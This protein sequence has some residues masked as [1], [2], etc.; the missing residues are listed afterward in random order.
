MYPF[1]GGINQRNMRKQLIITL[2]ITVAGSASAQS[3]W[4]KAHL[5]EVK[6]NLQQ[7]AYQTAYRHLIGEA[8]KTLQMAC[9]SVMLKDRVPASGDKHDYLSLSRYF[10]PDPT[11]PDGLPYISRDGVSNPELERLDRNRLSEMASGVTTLALAWYFSGNSQYAEKATD[12]LRTW[13]INKDTR[14][15]PHLTYAQI[16]PG[17]NGDKGRCYGVIDSYSFVEMLDAVQL[18]EGSKAFTPRDSKALKGWFSKFLNWLL[19]SEQGREEARQSNNHATAYDVQVMAYARYVGN[20]QVMDEVLGQFYEKRMRPQIE[21]DGSQPQ[22]LRRTLAFGYSEY[23]LTHIIDVFQMAR[24]AG[25]QQ[26][27]LPLLE[28]AADFLAKYL[29]KPVEAWPWQQISGW[30]EKQNALCQDLYR[31]YLLDNSRT[32]YQQQ[33]RQHVVKRWSDRFFLLYYT[34]DETDHAFAQAD[35]QLRYQLAQADSIR[36]EQKDWTLM[37]RCV[38]R[39]GSLR[40]VRQPDWCCGFFSG[41]LWQM[42]QYSH[43]PF[44]R[45]QAVS[46]TWPIERVKLNTGS[47]DLGFMVYNSFGKAWEQ[48]GEQSYRDVVVRAAKSLITR[49]DERVGCIRSW[50]WGTPDRWQ[51][52]V[53]ID[54]MIN[55][56]LLFQASLITGDKRYYNIA[57]SH[58]N[59]TMKHHFREDMTSYHVVDYNPEDGSVIKRITFQGLFDESVWSRGQGWGLYG[60]TMCYRYTHDKAYLEQARKIARCW[61]SLPDMPEDMIPWWDMR[62]PA[63]KTGVGPALNGGCP[64]DASAAAVIAAALYELA[65]YI[66]GDEA[67]TYRSAA[68]KMVHSLETSYTP[69][70]RTAQGFLLLHATGN[71]PAHDEIDVPINYAD[72]YYLEA[73][74]RRAQSKHQ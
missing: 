13:F 47:H 46:N 60:F 8:E 67:V 3:I 36:R 30:D 26:E 21:P 17:Q 42:Y 73:L 14:M 1:R 63:I 34:P 11:K 37:P 15:N 51:Y 59:T 55:L 53:I 20:K 65:T 56:E 72:Y 31:L 61:L 44:W 32:D 38:E 10:W 66:E 50:S 69:E 39:D 9:P 22:E 57:V 2:F 48:T 4:D 29:G 12:L 27:G 49:F 24:Q 43:D 45:E 64:R 16:V 19:T 54:N 68:D 18:L 71:Y 28:Q 23:N 41:E 35:G 6:D 62:D 7:P 52:A 5:S 70:P 25:Y 74:L 58:A 40:M 33:A